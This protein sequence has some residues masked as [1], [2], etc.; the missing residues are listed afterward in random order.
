MQ[1]WSWLGSSP[2]LTMLL[3]STLPG[4]RLDEPEHDVAQRKPSLVR[5]HADFA[6]DRGLVVEAI[7]AREAAHQ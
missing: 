1:G 6:F 2:D 4:P 3:A 5:S 7:L